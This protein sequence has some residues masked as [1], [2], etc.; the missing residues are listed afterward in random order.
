MDN[1]L[2][3]V[4]RDSEYVVLDVP[5][6]GGCMQWTVYQSILN[7]NYFSNIDIEGEWPEGRDL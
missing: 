2:N 4:E 7:K 5:T 3:V 6:V 1:P